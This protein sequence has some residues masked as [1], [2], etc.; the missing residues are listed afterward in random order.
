MRLEIM[1]NQSLLKKVEVLHV[2]AQNTGRQGLAN[3]GGIAA[4]LLVNG[5]TR[6]SF[7]TTHLE[8][9][10]GRYAT[11]VSTMGDIL[12]GTRETLH[13]CSLSAHHSFVMGDLNFRSEHPSRTEMG[14]EK[15]KEFVWALVER[16][17]WNGLYEL[18]ELSRA[19]REKHCLAGYRTLDCCF[20]PTFKLEREAGYTYVEQRLPSYTDRILWKSNHQMGKKVQP[21]VYEPIDT[22]ASSDHKPIR[23]AFLIELNTPF[24]LP[25]RFGS[26]SSSFLNLNLSMSDIRVPSYDHCHVFV[27]AINFKISQ[28]DDKSNWIPNP[29]LCLV[30]DPPD[31]LQVAPKSHINVFMSSLSKALFLPQSGTA[32]ESRLGFPRSSIQHST[33]ES[34]LGN[35]EICTEVS[36]HKST[37]LPLELSRTILFLTVMDHKP[38][39]PDDTVVGTVAVNL[40]ELMR[41]GRPVQNSDSTTP[42]QPQGLRGLL[43]RLRQQ[44]AAIFS[45]AQLE[46]ESDSDFVPIESIDIDQPLMKNGVEKGWLKCT[47]EA[48]W[49]DRSVTSSVEFGSER[50]NAS[51]RRK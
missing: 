11:R 21:L 35:E 33:F 29:Y 15:H 22:F 4:E 34:N 23:G 10:E 2:A 47:V 36:T 44:S 1:A 25:A 27:S 9:H 37:G 45:S 24:R 46:C 12:A 5:T 43:G 38:S 49:M 30:S 8:A 14:E 19:L 20:P 3:K 51:G 32:Q 48:W 50:R 42:P 6:L 31:C 16:E 26:Q 39:L 18:D 13:D 17:D 28:R 7:I 41:E 40:A